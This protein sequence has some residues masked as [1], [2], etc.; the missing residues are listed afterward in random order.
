MR[1]VQG[2]ALAQQEQT[3][4]LFVFGAVELEFHNLVAIDA[5]QIDFGG[6]FEERNGVGSSVGTSVAMGRTAASDWCAA[7]GVAAVSGGTFGV[8]DDG[9][10]VGSDCT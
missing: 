4:E 10:T 7:A 1:I 9:G 3:V 6:V 2:I 5:R 8:D